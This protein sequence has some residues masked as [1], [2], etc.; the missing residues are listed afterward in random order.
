M[1]MQVCEVLIPLPI[2]QGRNGA[3]F[4]RLLRCAVLATPQHPFTSEESL[5]S[6][7]FRWDGCTTTAKPLTHFDAPRIGSSRYERIEDATVRQVLANQR[8]TVLSPS[9][10]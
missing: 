7:S 10:Q 8:K 9:P 4:S 6:R 5:R 2:P 1:A 3:L